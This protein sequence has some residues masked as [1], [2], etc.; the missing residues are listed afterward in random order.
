MKGRVCDETLTFSRLGRF[1][2]RRFGGVIES[3]EDIFEARP[4]KRGIRTSSVEEKVCT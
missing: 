4:T 3:V 1:I 2:F